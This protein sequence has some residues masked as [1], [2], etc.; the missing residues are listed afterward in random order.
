MYTISLL[1]SHVCSCSESLQLILPNASSEYFTSARGLRPVHFSDHISQSFVDVALWKLEHMCCCVFGETRSSVTA[2]IAC[3]VVHKMSIVTQV[4]AVA[5]IHSDLY[6]DLVSVVTS[7]HVTKMAATPRNRLWS[8]T[9]C[10]TQ[11]VRR[12]VKQLL[13]IEA[14]ITASRNAIQGD[15]KVTDF[16]TPKFQNILVTCVLIDIT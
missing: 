11:T 8:K 5:R 15:F 2:D 12:C 4:R 16:C 6:S 13:S 1:W 9:R 3:V 14:L 7:D 10:Q